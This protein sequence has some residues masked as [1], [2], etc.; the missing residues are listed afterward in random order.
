MRLRAAC[1][2]RRLAVDAIVEDQRAAP[3]APRAVTL[4]QHADDRVE[5]RPGKGAVR[6]G[7]ADQRVE[8]R[9]RPT[10]RRRPRRRSAAPA[11]RAAVGIVEPVEL[12]AP[13]GVEQRAALHQ[14]V[15][16]EREQPPLGVPST[17]WP[18]RPDALQEGRD[19]ARRAELADEVHVADVDA[20]ARATRSRPAPCSSPRFS[21]C[22][23]SRRRSR[24]RLPWCARDLS[25]P[26]RSD[27]WR[28]TRSAMPPRVD[29]DERR[30][31]RLDQ[32]R[33]AVVDL[34]PDVAR[35]HGFE[36]RRRQLEARSRVAPVADV[37]DRA[38]APGAPSAPAPTRK[39][40][41]SSIGFCVADRPIAHSRPP[42]APSS[43]SSDS[44]RCVPRLFGGERVDLVDDHGAR[45]RE[46]A[47]GRTPSR[48]GCRA[49]PAW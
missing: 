47:R 5:I 29:E 46:H 15:A 37:D 45:R 32:L 43:R 2:A 39:R 28:A 8:L 38:L 6:V 9:R 34:L 17:P 40:A 14:L 10:P 12:A 1:R 30:A 25:S 21:R 36:R 26:R 11:R 20:R 7:A 24:D 18:E 23:A 22:S 31:V 44:A 41:I 3:P 19:R 13:H 27:S 33:E 16:R 42:R 35:H 48:A 49:T 4:A